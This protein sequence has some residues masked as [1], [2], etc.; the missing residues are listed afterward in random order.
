MIKG[1]TRN[2]LKWIESHLLAK[3]VYRD[4]EIPLGSTVWEGWMQSFLDRVQTQLRI[5]TQRDD[6]EVLS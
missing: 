3:R 1:L 5:S 2:E 6:Y 4:T